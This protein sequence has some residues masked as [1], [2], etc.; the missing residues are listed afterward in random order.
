MSE[1]SISIV[2]ESK[3]PM[4]TVVFLAWPIF[5]EQLLVSLVQAVDTAMVGSLG[6]VATAS[7]AINSS[8]NNLINGVLMAMG[9][10]FTS[11]IARSIGAGDN[12]R[13]RSL[14]KQAIMVVFYIGLPL[15]VLYF[16]FAGD[17][18]RWLGGEEE[19]LLYAMQYNKIIA[20]SLVFRGMTT[21]LTAI[22]RGYGDSRTPMITNVLV[23]FLNVIGNYIC[24]YPTREI[25]FLGSTFSMFGFGW[26]VAGAAVSTSLSNTL[27][28]LILLVLSFVRKGEMQIDLKSGFA[29]D[30]PELRNV[31]KISFPAMLERCA[32]QGSFIM[33]TYTV[34]SL[35]TAAIAANNLSG[36]IESLSFMPGFAFGMSMTTLFGQALGAERP[37]LARL[38]VIS[39]IKLGTVIMVFTSLFL[40][41]GSGTVIKLFTPDAE[42]IEMGST[43]LKILAVIQIPQ[44]ITM[45]F[46]G[47]LRGAG[48][49]KS[50]FIIVLISMWGV[51]VLGSVLCVRVFHLGLSAVCVCTCVDNVVRCCLFYLRYRQGKWKTVNANT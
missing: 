31:F 23:N 35:G 25:T 7:V 21:M 1:K 50:S 18:P 24:I 47:S 37:D 26:G 44:M 29:P 27:G 14:I 49:S 38:Y 33:M 51:R 22:Y 36:T 16:I 48:D 45:V 30:A 4:H 34:A 40:F 20:F 2:D 6:K 43:L 39:T 17:I 42:V 11:L 28:G 3:R 15:S 19:I 41:F 46:S 8:P 13:A 10:G 32:M 9:I 5:L 12:S